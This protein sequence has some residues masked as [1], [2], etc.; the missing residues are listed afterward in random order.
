MPFPLVHF[1]VGLSIHERLGREVTPEFLLGSIAPDAIHTRP[2]TTRPDKRHTHL[3]DTGDPWPKP[4][5]HWLG[6]QPS[7]DPPYVELVRGY[8]THLLTDR[9]WARSIVDPY[10]QQVQGLAED[11]LKALYYRELDQ[12][13]MNLYRHAPWRP[14][15]W[16]KLAAA[17]AQDIPELLSAQEID[18]WR[19]IT[20]GWGELP[21]KD[22]G[23]MPEHITEAQVERFID[24]AAK[25]V[26]ET[27]GSWG[28]L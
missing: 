22:P 14:G 10:R 27:M 15:V 23:I 26:Y 12:I 9:F 16:Q 8:A 5:R 17:R 7:D 13:D 25:M 24:E 3:L 18:R 2:N 11:R 6:E 20:L 19:V 1:A 21:E 4:A 28:E